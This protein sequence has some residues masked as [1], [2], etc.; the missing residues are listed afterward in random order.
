MPDL[1]RVVDARRDVPSKGSYTSGL[2]ADENAMLKKII[3]EAGEFALAAKDG[4]ADEMAWE[5][6]DLIY[7]VMVAVERT[8]LPMDKVFRKLSER[9]R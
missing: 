6:A 3:E 7:H 1:K 9:R 5:L 2:M 8:G 4:D